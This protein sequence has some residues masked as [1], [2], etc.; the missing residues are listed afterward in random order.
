LEF[1]K[2]YEILILPLILL[3]LGLLLE[4]ASAKNFLEC[5]A[6]Y[7]SIIV[8]ALLLRVKILS[9]LVADLVDDLTPNFE[10]LIVA[11]LEVLEIPPCGHLKFNSFFLLF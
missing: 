2:F 10:A 3:W 9:S 11:G 8:S 6:I 1:D 5:V 7:F 4:F